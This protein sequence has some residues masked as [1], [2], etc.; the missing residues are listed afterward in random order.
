MYHPLHVRYTCTGTV[1]ALYTTVQ[2]VH[3]RTQCTRTRT[4]TCIVRYK[5]GRVR[6]PRVRETERRKST[7]N[8]NI[9][10][11]GRR[12]VYL[13]FSR[14]GVRSKANPAL[15]T[16]LPMN[17]HYSLRIG[18]FTILNFAPPFILRM[19]NLSS[20]DDVIHIE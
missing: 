17:R 2:Y 7:Q 15:I 14:K 6:S 11:R 13:G 10:K 18:S 20:F 9:R 16:V 5:K 1:Y 19:R 8:N 4:I 3:V 12:G